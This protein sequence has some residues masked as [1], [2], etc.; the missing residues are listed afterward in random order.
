[1]LCRSC[2]ALCVLSSGVVA[3]VCCIRLC[4]WTGI[5]LCCVRRLQGQL[6]AD[7][8][9]MS[10]GGKPQTGRM[11]LGNQAPRGAATDAR[12]AEAELREVE[13]QADELGKVRVCVFLCALVYVDEGNRV[14][15]VGLC[16][17]QGQ[18]TL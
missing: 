10:G 4:G 3:D 1:M 11:A 16:I 9:T 8:G 2:P 5:V 17:K 15:A 14:C 13:R 18:Y 12:A 6:I 7:S